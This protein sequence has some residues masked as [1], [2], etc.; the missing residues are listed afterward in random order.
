MPIITKPYAMIRF[1]RDRRVTFV[2][3]NLFTSRKGKNIFYERDLACSLYI[4][5]KSGPEK[6]RIKVYVSLLSVLPSG[7]STLRRSSFRHHVKAL[8][9]S[10]IFSVLFL[11]SYMLLA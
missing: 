10:S 1:F 2:F 4:L 11:Y 3:Y 9:F 7:N 6:S 5:D 8:I